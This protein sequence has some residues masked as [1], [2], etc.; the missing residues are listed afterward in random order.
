MYQYYGLFGWC[1][2][3]YF[4][5]ECAFFAILLRSYEGRFFQ[6]LMIFNTFVLSSM[7]YALDI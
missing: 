2:T 6:Y 4:Q 1:C 3:M 5:W 7:L